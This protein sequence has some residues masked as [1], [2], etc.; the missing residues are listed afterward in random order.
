MSE[1]KGTSKP[2]AFLRLFAW[3]RSSN[4]RYAFTISN[5]TSRIAGDGRRVPR[6]SFPILNPGKIAGRSDVTVRPMS[7]AR[8]SLPGNRASGEPPQSLID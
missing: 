1:P 7:E 3:R 6:C 8:S 2:R 4:I 5:R